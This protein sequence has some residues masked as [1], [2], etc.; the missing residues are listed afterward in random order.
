MQNL[1]ILQHVCEIETYYLSHLYSWG[2]G[3]FGKA[4]HRCSITQ[5]SLQ[6]DRQEGAETRSQFPPNT[7]KHVLFP[8]VPSVLLRQLGAF[9]WLDKVGFSFS[10]EES[11]S[12]VVEGGRWCLGEDGEWEASATVTSSVSSS[13][14]DAGTDCFTASKAPFLWANLH[15]PCAQNQ[16]CSF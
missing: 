6:Q 12:L 3:A 8:S 11:S 9:P 2:T 5:E 7:I 4:K 13:F 16:P 10:E 1:F 14:P 15:S